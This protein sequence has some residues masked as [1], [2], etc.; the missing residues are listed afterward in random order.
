M[1]MQQ[2]VKLKSK[3]QKL[4]LVLLSLFLFFIVVIIIGIVN[5]SRG[6]NQDTIL[7]PSFF[8]S[9]GIFFILFGF[10]GIARGQLIEKWTPWVLG[11]WI[12]AMTRLFVKQ[13]DDK[14]KN[15]WKISLGITALIAGVV[16]IAT[17]S[18][19]LYRHI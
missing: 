1:K 2:D 13:E 18:Y 8:F 5:Q 16:C 15:A 3:E 17:G 7:T 10:N 19:D 11:S 14:E 12:K 6:I 4:E 9:G